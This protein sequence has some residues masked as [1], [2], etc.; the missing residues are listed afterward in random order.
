MGETS[1]GLDEN[2]EG[3]LCYL[4]GWLTGIVFF[5]LEKDNRFVKFHA[6]Q[7]IVVFFGLMILMWIIGAITTAMMV[8]ASMMGSGMIASLFTLV[9]VLIQL[10]IFGLW[11]FLMYK[12][13]SGEMYKVPVIGDWVESKI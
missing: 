5:V 8:G 2:I 10:V 12:A 3:A 4:L 1:I 7:S 6:M 9:M 11:L 13:Y